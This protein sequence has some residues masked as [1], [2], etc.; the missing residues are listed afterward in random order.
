MPVS[1]H[2]YQNDFCYRILVEKRNWDQNE[3]IL[4][5]ITNSNPKADGLKW[6]A[7]WIP[8]IRQGEKGYAARIFNPFVRGVPANAVGKPDG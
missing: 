6:R 3:H 7:I 2:R 4:Q 8:D 1:R 5:T